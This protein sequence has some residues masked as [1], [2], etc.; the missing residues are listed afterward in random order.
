MEYLSLFQVY[1]CSCKILVI[2]G[3][4]YFL[5][6]C[7]PFSNKIFLSV[8]GGMYFFSTKNT[9]LLSFGRRKILQINSSECWTVLIHT[10][11][12]IPSHSLSAVQQLK[13]A[14]V[15]VW[16]LNSML[17]PLVLWLFLVLIW[18]FKLRFSKK[19][20]IIWQIPHLICRLHKYLKNVKA[21]GI[22]HQ[23][24]RKLEL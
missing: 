12:K 3:G 5:R 10:S 23:I 20:T 15:K 6:H 24:L 8:K 19:V 11:G 22:F 18:T 21:I 14:K 13:I 9:V 2:K 17:F 16:F 4:A 1:D 7:Q